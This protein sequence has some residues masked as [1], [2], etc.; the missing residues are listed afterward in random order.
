MLELHFGISIKQKIISDNLD[1]W[2]TDK[3]QNRIKI[4]TSQ[5]ISCYWSQNY[6]Y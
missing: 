2:C 6:C 3:S 4:L 1:Y 5:L